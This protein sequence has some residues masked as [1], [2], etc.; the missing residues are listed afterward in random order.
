M[1]IAIFVS[2]KS[3]T[4]SHSHDGLEP[5][6]HEHEDSKSINYF[7]NYELEDSNYG[8]KTTVIVNNVTRTMVTNALPNH[9]TGTFPNKGN[10]NTISAQNKTYTFPANPQYNGKA[11]WVRESGV[12]LNGVKFE[13]GTAEVVECD[14]GENY[15]VEALQDVIDLGLDFN[16]AHVQ[17]TGAYHY[18]GSPTSVIEEFDTGEDL[19]HI[20]F[21]HDGFPMFYSKSG[22]YKPSF[23][24]V[25]GEREG[26]DC[27]YTTH[28]TIDVSVDGH[29]DGTFTSDFEFVEG[30]GDLDECN[31][32]T[33]DGKYMYLVTNEFP[34]ISRCLMGEVL[35]EEKQQI[36]MQGEGGPQNGNGSGHR[37]SATEIIKQMDANNDGKLS[38]S[39]AKGPLKED[40]SKIDANND[41]FISS[42]ELEKGARNN[43][44]RPPKHN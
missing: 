39:E 17:P 21:A 40:F 22:K 12:A 18:H 25:E 20:G 7:G 10:P 44:Q 30:S 2:C 11:Q 28:K 16:H 19:V 8:T 43:K 34:Y 23:K 15:R 29:H 36:G 5:H 9:E 32:I 33:I 14:T 6:T 31:G 26:E 35:S 3:N 1:S 4:N 38:K 41:G 13:P 27:T 42:E 37:P 24:A